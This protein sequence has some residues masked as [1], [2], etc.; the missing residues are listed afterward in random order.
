ME[1][2]LLFVG[3]VIVIAIIA[4]AVEASA[5]SKRTSEEREAVSQKRNELSLAAAHGPINFALICPHCSD[6]G[7]VRT[8]K[9][10]SKK[11][12]SGGKATGA[13]LTGGISLLATGLSRKEAHTQ[14][15]CENCSSTW[16][17]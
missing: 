3:L 11:G 8:K 7:K 12:I 17:F 6:K 1:M 14:A 13:L 4:G 2:F 5:D 10:V 16:D 15:H 9:L